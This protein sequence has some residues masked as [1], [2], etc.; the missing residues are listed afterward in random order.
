MMKPKTISPRPPGG[1]RRPLR[2]GISR[3][4]LGDEVR[5]DGGHKREVFLTETL[6]QFVQWVPVCPEVEV[7]MGVPR[8]PVHLIGSATS[9]RLVTVTSGIDHTGA[10]TRFSRKRVRE[11]E[12]L[13]LSGYVFKKDS[14]SCGMERVRVFDRH[15]T[16]S[17]QGVGMFARVFM[18]HFPL[19]PVEDEGRL[20][21][22]ILRE[23]FL[24][25]IFAYGRWQDF[26]QG[27]PTRHALVR[28]HTAHKYQLLAHSRT[29][30]QALGRLVAEADRYTPTA[31]ARRYGAL[32]MECLKVR[33]TLRKNTN[34]L[35]H[36]AGHFTS[37]LSRPERVEFLDMIEE[38]RQGL[39]P[40]IVP[41][42]LLR[43]HVNRLGIDYL[44]D[45]V[46][47]NPHPK[48]LMLRNR[49]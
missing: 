40:L 35:Q 31:L 26:M 47:L 10:M 48:E 19:I 7:G 29:R 17:R 9:P 3:C 38:Y 23:N 1:L 20:N 42:V 13:D 12:A 8:E 21:N 16:P 45:Q 11:L 5:F 6:S 32:F 28:F 41:I 36:M 49:I 24:E 44:Q 14:P 18:Q 37:R 22:P 39:I 30:Y 2:L 46:Y 25:R 33:A 4:L 27:A 43:H 34:V 15:G